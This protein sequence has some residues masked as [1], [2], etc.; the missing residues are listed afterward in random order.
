MLAGMPC[1]HATQRD[2]GQIQKLNMRALFQILVI[3]FRHT[4]AGLEFAVLKRSDSDC[5]QFVAGG[6]DDGETPI[7]SAARETWEEVGISGQERM[8]G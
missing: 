4:A 2:Q 6:G 5:W 7:Q 1:W 8:T 3:P